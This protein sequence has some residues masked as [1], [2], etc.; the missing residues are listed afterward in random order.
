M[1]NLKLQEGVNELKNL[2]TLGLDSYSYQGMYALD[3]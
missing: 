3:C 2:E 1:I